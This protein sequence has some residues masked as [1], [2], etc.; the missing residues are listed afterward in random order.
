MRLLRLA[1]L[2]CAAASARGCGFTVHQVI[3]RRAAAS[4][5]QPGFHAA[6]AR[7][8]VALLAARPGALLAGAPFPDYLYECG[9][10]HDDGEYAHWSPWQGHAAEHVRGW[11][12]APWSD[13]QAEVVAFIH[14]ATSH[15][16]ADIAWHGL[17]EV[18]GGLGLIQTVGMLDYNKTG[19]DST[20]HS[21]CDTGGEFVAAYA[22]DVAF[23]A[24][25]EWV[26]PTADLVA[27]FALAGRAVNASDID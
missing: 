10:N 1:A 3:A 13:A 23:L 27:I 24:P 7:G 22:S 26:V 19:L 11:G 9:A 4:Y 20:A 16:I 14:G 8:Y 5:L 2:S 6:S 21:E 17:A 18:R 25:Q 15:Y 12:P